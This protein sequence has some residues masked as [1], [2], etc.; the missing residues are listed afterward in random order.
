MQWLFQYA[1]YLYFIK[2]RAFLAALQEAEKCRPFS[3][4]LIFRDLQSGVHFSLL[5]KKL[6]NA[7]CFSITSLSETYKTTCISRE[8]MD[9]GRHQSYDVSRGI[10]AVV[11]N[12][13]CRKPLIVEKRGTFHRGDSSVAV[14]GTPILCL[15][16]AIH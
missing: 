6:R 14:G 7:D 12:S 4:R 9:G 8:S 16:I 13:Y 3:N 5:Y 2:L 11:V 15:I 10:G 1:H